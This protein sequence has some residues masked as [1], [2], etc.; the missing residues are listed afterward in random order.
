MSDSGNDGQRAQDVLDEALMHA[1]GDA[2]AAARILAH[3]VAVV[4]EDLERA[5]GFISCGFV[6]ATL[7]E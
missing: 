5:R 4:L 7:K 6:R 1:G 2:G 3:T